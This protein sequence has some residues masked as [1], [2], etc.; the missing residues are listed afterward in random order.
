M[1]MYLLPCIINPQNQ[2][3]L[4]LKKIHKI[5]Q[6]EQSK[7]LKPYIDLNTKLRQE[8]DNKFEEGFAKLMNNSFFG[9][10]N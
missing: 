8:A 10:Y 3:G 9:K 4:K 5:L 7:W 2:N 6:F 1:T